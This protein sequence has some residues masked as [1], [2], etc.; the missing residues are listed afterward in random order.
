MAKNITTVRRKMIKPLEQ[1]AQYLIKDPKIKEY[2]T[3][4]IRAATAVGSTD[5]KHSVIIIENDIIEYKKK[6]IS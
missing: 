4:I 6:E 3:G 1:S 5:L 2:A